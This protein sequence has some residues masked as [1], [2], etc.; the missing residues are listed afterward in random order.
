[1]YALDISITGKPWAPMIHS[2]YQV[3]QTV[4]KGRPKYVS[5]HNASIYTLTSDWAPDTARTQPLA[6][7]VYS[8]DCIRVIQLPTLSSRQPMLKA[9]IK[10]K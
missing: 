3:F 7:S 1:M 8:F 4:S 9:E 2:S 5:T 10:L 6:R